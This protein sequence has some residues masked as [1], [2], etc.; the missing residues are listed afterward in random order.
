MFAGC[1]R[2]FEGNAQE[3]HKAL[4]ET[5]AALPDDTRVYV[6]VLVLPGKEVSQ[7]MRASSRA[8]STPRAMS[9]S[10]PPCRSRSRLR[11]CRRL[12]RRT[13]RPRASLRS[14]MRR[15]AACRLPGGHSGLTT[16][17]ASQRVHACQCTSLATVDLMIRL[18]ITGPG[19][20]EG[21][22][23]DEPGGGDG[24]TEGDE[25]CHVE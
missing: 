6:G 24:Q 7:L 14:G 13:S 25:E 8:T 3:M 22:W 21:H 9:S 19:D 16:A 12:W 23:E 15:Y 11:S 1:G 2:F 20:P 5:L 18:T 10:A 4:N 17:S